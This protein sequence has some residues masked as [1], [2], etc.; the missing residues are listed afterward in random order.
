MKRKVT[1]IIMLVMLAAGLSLM[2]YPTFANWWN[3]SHGLK[4]IQ[5]YNEAVAEIDPELKEKL[6]KEAREHNRNLAENGQYMQLSDEKMK[7]YKKYLR[8]KNNPIMGYIEIKKCDISLP[9]YHG[10]SDTVLNYG[11]GHLE[12]SS[13]P[14]GGESTHCVLSGHRGLPS[15][16]LFTDI[17]QLKEGDTFAINIMDEIMTYEVD[18]I[19]IVKPEDI[20]ALQIENGQD[21]CTLVTCTPYGINTHRLL[22]RG[23]RIENI[24]DRIRVTADAVQIDT[25][26]T[27]SVIS[28]PM[29]LILIVIMLVKTKKRRDV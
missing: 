3:Q 10:T 6:L 12:W 2:L 9:I 8:I 15:A 22:V 24:N 25:K 7:Q 1:T 19:L 27:A 21:L 26:I 16:R 20:S 17:D 18:Q 13:L 23:H 29:L 11:A 5:S 28:I 4:V 14:V